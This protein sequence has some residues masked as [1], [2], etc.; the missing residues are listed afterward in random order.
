M[1]KTPEFLVNTKEEINDSSLK[2]LKTLVD[3]YLEHQEK[4]KDLEEELKAEKKLFNQYNQIEIPEFLLQNGLSQIKLDTGE[5]IIIKENISVTINNNELFFDFLIT[6]KESDII[7][8]DFTFDKMATTKLNELYN[9]LNQFNYDYASKK[10]V[11][12]QTKKKYFKELLGIGKDDIEEGLKNKKYLKKED[13]ESFAK[14][15]NFF[16]T[17]IK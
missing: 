10:D 3:L 5:K 1:E 4:V 2:E 6:R 12:G 11:H 14:V 16:V 13:I 7:K 9:F 15:F 17:K 8:T